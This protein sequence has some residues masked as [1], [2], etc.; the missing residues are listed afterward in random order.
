MNKNEEGGVDYGPALSLTF[1]YIQESHEA[2]GKN[3]VTHCDKIRRLDSTV[4][5]NKGIDPDV[6]NKMTG[7]G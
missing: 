3:L 4:E 5:P 2:T 1:T 7:V 6:A